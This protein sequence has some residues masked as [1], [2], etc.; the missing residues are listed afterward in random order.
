MELLATVLTVLLLRE[1]FKKRNTLKTY[2]LEN[3]DRLSDKVVAYVDDITRQVNV[4]EKE[5]ESMLRA[6]RSTLYYMIVRECASSGHTLSKK[7]KQQLGK[8]FGV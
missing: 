2:I 3:A 5:R 8:A 7:E 6:S 4:S 1:R